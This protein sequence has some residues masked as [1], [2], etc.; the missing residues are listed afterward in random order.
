MKKTILGLSAALLIA[1]S[2]IVYA[3]PK[4]AKATAANERACDPD[5]DCICV[6]T[7]DGGYVCVPK[8]SATQV[9]LAAAVD[10]PA[11]P[12]TDD[13]ICE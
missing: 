2:L 8:S 7:P 3:Q 10:K 9:Q 1:T 11:C 12:N 5:E 13:C 6:P 4:E